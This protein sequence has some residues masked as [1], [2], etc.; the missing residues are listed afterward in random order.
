MLRVG[1]TPAD[2]DRTSFSVAEE[3]RVIAVEAVA[4][5][6]QIAG[7][8]CGDVAVARVFPRPHSRVFLVELV[9][10]FLGRLRR[11]PPFESLLDFVQSVSNARHLHDESS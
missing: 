4:D 1:D 3:L 5:G 10:R 9:A 7:R 8:A 6:L 11:P 2:R